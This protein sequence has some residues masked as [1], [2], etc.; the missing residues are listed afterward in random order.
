MNIRSSHPLHR[1]RSWFLFLA[2]IPF[3]PEIVIL[4]TA[5]VAVLMGWDRKGSCTFASEPVTKIIDFSL[6]VSASGILALVEARLVWLLLFYLCIS[7]WLSLCLV[8]ASRGWS[9]TLG[10]LLVG[11]CAAV[12]FAF[13]PYF[14]PWLS[15]ASFL[16]ENCRP[17]EGYVG[18]CVMFGGYVGNA[19][20][21]I[22]IG[23]LALYGVPL[24]SAIFCVYAMVT[25]F[26]GFHRKRISQSYRRPDVNTT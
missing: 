9:S 16:N 24:A 25:V 12:A 18:A 23:W 10:R 1:Y 3:F 14:G 26:L 2:V 4:V 11:F 22:N 20:D 6:E 13:L 17:N 15:I 19:H 8:L 5:T 21:T 7:A